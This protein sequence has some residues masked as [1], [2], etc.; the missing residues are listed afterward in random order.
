MKK[1][2][3]DLVEKLRTAANKLILLDYDGTLVNYSSIPDNAVPTDQLLDI[4]LNLSN[5]PKTNVIIITGRKS[6]DIDKFFGLLP[7]DI[8]AG[9]G[10]MI[11]GNLK[12]K[13]CI[14]AVGLWKKNTLL[15]LNEYT[16]KCPVHL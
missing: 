12:W 10:A 4:L 14:N 8:V 9:H 5:A 15:L 7:V 6:A 11:K 3:E 1:V 2:R 13:T 16:S